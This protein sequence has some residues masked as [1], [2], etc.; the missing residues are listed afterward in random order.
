MKI[1]EEGKGLRDLKLPVKPL[2]FNNLETVSEPD[3]NTRGRAATWKY[4]F[5][6]EQGTHAFGFV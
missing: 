2:K 4:F 3:R 1:K 6:A 5:T